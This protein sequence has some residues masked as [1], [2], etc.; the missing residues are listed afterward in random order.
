MADFLVALAAFD[1]RRGWEALGHANLFAFLHVEL[2][3][4]NPSAHWRMSAAWALQRFPDLI[5]PLRDGRLCCTATAE[6]AKVLTDENVETVLPRFFGLSAREAQE[7]VAELQPRL[8]AATRTVVTG[9]PQIRKA[10]LTFSS[11]LET[12]APT[13]LPAPPPALHPGV[14]PPSQLRTS[15]VAFGGGGRPHAPRDETE[16]LTADLRRLHITVSRQLLK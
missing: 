12:A 11:S 13:A 6:L 10:P 14:A 1:A 16:P 7:L 9:T 15:E 5:S 2:K 3:L 4:P 8:A